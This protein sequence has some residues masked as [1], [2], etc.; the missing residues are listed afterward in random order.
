MAIIIKFS[1]FNEFSYI[2][3]INFLSFWPKYLCFNSVKIAIYKIRGYNYLI[4]PYM[5]ASCID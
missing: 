3:F 1:R 4:N 5:E 2:K